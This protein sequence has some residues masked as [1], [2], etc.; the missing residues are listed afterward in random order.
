MSNNK[1][2]ALTWRQLNKGEWV[3]FQLQGWELY[4]GIYLGQGIFYAT[5]IT[6]NTNPSKHLAQKMDLKWMSNKIFNVLEEPPKFWR[7]PYPAV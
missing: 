3:R 6:L 7:P 4:E 2:E 5:S 1:Y